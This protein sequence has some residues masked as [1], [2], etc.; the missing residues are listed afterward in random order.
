VRDKNLSFTS[1]W[2]K[3]Y[4]AW[5]SSLQI[6]IVTTH[7]NRHQASKMNNDYFK[8]QNRGN[9][10]YVTFKHWQKVFDG[11]VKQGGYSED[12]GYDTSG[13]KIHSLTKSPGRNEVVGM[14]VKVSPWLSGS[15][16]SG[17]LTLV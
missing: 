17:A 6:R 2:G 1:G 10:S 8:P 16:K 5:F 14:L 15:F 7:Y 13:S 9:M 12:V 4:K 3:A 11:F